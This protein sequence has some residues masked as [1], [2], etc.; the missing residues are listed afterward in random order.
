MG[1]DI[2]CPKGKS[3]YVGAYSKVQR[4]RTQS[5]LMTIEWLKNEILKLKNGNKNL[6]AES[7][8]ST[9]SA[10]NVESKCEASDDEDDDEDDDDE[11]RKN[12]EENLKLGLEMVTSWLKTRKSFSDPSDTYLWIEYDLIPK[13]LPMSL[14]LDHDIPLSGLY[15]WVNHSD[16]EG[17]W[18]AG[19]CLDI[20][21][22]FDKIMLQCDVLKKYKYDEASELRDTGDHQYYTDIRNVFASAVENKS[23]VNCQ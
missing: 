20:L 13:W 12:K 1:L 15:W 3:F 5:I 9:E 8:E 22:W 16:C 2:E 21:L 19:M 10:E 14:C 4:I 23:V 7:K 17:S 6:V 11:N 18:T